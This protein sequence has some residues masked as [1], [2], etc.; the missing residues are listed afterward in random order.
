M[1]SLIQ[2][3]SIGLWLVLY[4]ALHVIASL[5]FHQR[6]YQVMKQKDT[7]RNGMLWVSSNVLLR[8]FLTPA[9]LLLMIYKLISVGLPQEV[10]FLTLIA[11]YLVFILPVYS[12]NR[13]QS[14]FVE[15][16]MTTDTISS[17]PLFVFFL[18]RMP[19]EF[20]RNMVKWMFFAKVAGLWVE[21]HFWNMA[22]AFVLVIVYNSLEEAVT[23]KKKP[24]KQPEKASEQ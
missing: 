24:E 11:T 2:E 21:N 10:S 3:A 9:I 5:F 1:I 4:M 17:L 14:R 7:S 13:L 23:R 8:T 20:L 6:A 15:R 18:F 22:V 16:G 19:F 12:I